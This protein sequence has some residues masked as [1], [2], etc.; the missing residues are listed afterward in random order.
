MRAL[1]SIKE[2]LANIDADAD[3]ES[4][5]GARLG[6]TAKRLSLGKGKK[7]TYRAEKAAK[8]KAAMEEDSSDED[9]IDDSD[10]PAKK[11][12][13]GRKTP[14]A[15]KTPRHGCQMAIARS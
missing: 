9:F 4:D 10:T 8:K 11:T 7:A 5:V 1:A 15:P 2:D 12:P 6:N 3:L 13:K 14:K